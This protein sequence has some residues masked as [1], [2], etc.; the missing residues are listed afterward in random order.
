VVWSDHDSMGHDA[1]GT[2]RDLIAELRGG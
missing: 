1:A 2:Y